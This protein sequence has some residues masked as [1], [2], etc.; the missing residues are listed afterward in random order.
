M[1]S[2]FT[3]KVALVAISPAPSPFLPPVW[4]SESL[5]QV[6]AANLPHPQKPSQESLTYERPTM[7]SVSDAA[8]EADALMLC[9]LSARGIDNSPNDSGQ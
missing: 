1:K 9:C 3:S 2:E 4:K 7:P 8:S 6:L 5:L